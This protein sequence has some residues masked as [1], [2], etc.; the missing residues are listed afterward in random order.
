[1]K[2]LLANTALLLLAG[3]IT[4]VALCGVMVA[5]ENINASIAVGSMTM[6]AAGSVF[7]VPA[8]SAGNAKDLVAGLVAGLGKQAKATKTVY[9]IGS[10]VLEAIGNRDRDLAKHINNK[11]NQRGALARKDVLV[12]VPAVRTLRAIDA[13][14]AAKVADRHPGV[15]ELLKRF[16]AADSAPVTRPAE[17]ESTVSKSVKADTKP[18]A[19]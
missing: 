9:V 11:L 8:P 16:D 13:A 14:A 10:Q 5:S 17:T 19:K 6:L 18:T 1:M 2:F 12:E 15:K 4:L 3:V 7:A